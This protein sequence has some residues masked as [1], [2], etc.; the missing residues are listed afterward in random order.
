M[1]PDVDDEKKDEV[2]IELCDTLDTLPDLPVQNNQQTNGHETQ[3][4][5]FSPRNT[6]NWVL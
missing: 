4:N 3:K 5:S 1:L 2:C 6:G